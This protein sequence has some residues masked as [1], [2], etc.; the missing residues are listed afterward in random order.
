MVLTS[1][2]KFIETAQRNK[3]SQDRP[4]DGIISWP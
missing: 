4:H 2:V 1:V 3:N